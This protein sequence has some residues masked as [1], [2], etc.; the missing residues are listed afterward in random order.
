[1]VVMRS[2]ITDL[3]S[4]FRKHY[5][6]HARFYS[7]LALQIFAVPLLFTV[8]TRSAVTAV[9]LSMALVSLTMLLTVHISVKDMRS[10]YTYMI[11]NTLP[12]R[13][14]VR[15]G[16]IL[17]NSTVVV[18]AGFL[19]LYLPS[20][21][22]SCWLFPIDESFQ[23][24]LDSAF[25][26]NRAAFI[27]ILGIHALI[28]IVNV[29]VRKRPLVGYV[30]AALAMMAVSYLVRKYIELEYRDMVMMWIY[31]VTIATSWIGSYFLLRK[32]Q[33]KS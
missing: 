4:L 20:L 33:F 6:E 5:V 21:W 1:M 17:L 22:L 8:L 23:W 19:V 12:V 3:F 13:S 11:E 9:T 25:F 24:V 15:Y 2:Y 28:L 27:N 10:R 32:F 14:G 26:N 31:I 29:L 16:F 7:L 18:L 30:L